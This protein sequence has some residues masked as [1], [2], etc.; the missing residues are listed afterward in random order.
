MEPLGASDY[1]WGP[2]LILYLSR[3]LLVFLL[4]CPSLSVSPSN[5]PYLENCLMGLQE[6]PGGSIR[7]A[8]G[9]SIRATG[10]SRRLQEVPGGS[11]RLQEAPG[12]SRQASRQEWSH[13]VP[14]SVFGWDYYF[15]WDAQAP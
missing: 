15:G 10:G 8:P 5:Y 11:R 9:G 3:D 2:T 14:I 4:A 12:G 1:Y 7:E 13:S 6:A